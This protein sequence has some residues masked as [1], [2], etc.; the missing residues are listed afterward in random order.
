MTRR[1]GLEISTTAVRIA[2]VASGGDQPRLLGYAQVRL[3]AGTVVDGVIADADA[4]R[5]AIQRC[6]R[7]GGFGGALRRRGGGRLPVR[8]SIA[9][10]Q[11]IMREIEMPPVPPAEI[12]AAVQLQAI[13]I[14]PFPQ[15]LTLF[16]ARPLGTAADENGAPLMRVLLA[17]AHRELVDAFVETT[18]AAGLQPVGVELAASAMVRALAASAA[19][20]EPEAI[21]SVGADL[22]TVVVHQLG[23]PLFV[24]TIAEGGNA[25]TQAL[26][27][28]LD[29][30]LADAENLKRHLG[31]GGG[32]V[33][34]EA[35][36][37]SQ[38]GTA[39]LL[40]EIRSSIDYFAALPGRSEVSRVV[41]TGAGAQLAGLVERLQLQLAAPVVRGSVFQQLDTSDIGADLQPFGA[42]DLSSAVAVGLAMPPRPGS[43]ELDLLPR[44][45]RAGQRR[46]RTE[47]RII[48]A[49]AAIVAALVGTG[50]MRWMSLEHAEHQ[51][52][53]L[54]AKVHLLQAQL[55]KYD[56]V[57]REDAEL[58]ADQAL[59]APLVANEVNWLGALAA[60]KRYTPRGLSVTSFS[61]QQTTGAVQSDS[62]SALPAPGALLAGLSVSIEG[63]DLAGFKSWMASIGGSQRFVIASWSQLSASKST[64]TWS[65]SLQLTG[66]VHTTRLRQY[67]VTP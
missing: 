31:E 11:A 37:A 58:Q 42:I 67:E 27:T 39:R 9:G 49:A 35:L 47:T 63:P 30:P 25:V 33:P 19:W 66:L 7:E 65:A 61:G 22:T 12:D 40:S 4:V 45:V 52:A 51:V 16:S 53:V 1:I 26:A 18:L 57:E 21:V 54:Q 3:P 60:L 8:L 28:A 5:A 50:V 6:A 23:D 38:E 43:K 46:R 24:R 14:V 56:V 48:A 10:L 64:T 59:A 15:E 32:S 55:P 17:A 62:S 20:P 44:E 2:E 41:V 36:H 34:A 29:L 13:D